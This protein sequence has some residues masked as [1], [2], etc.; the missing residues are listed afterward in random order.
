MFNFFLEKIVSY[1]NKISW[2]LNQFYLFL[3]IRSNYIENIWFKKKKTDFEK[4]SAFPSMH[5]TL[6]SSS[7]FTFRSPLIHSIF[8]PFLTPKDIDKIKEILF[9]FLINLSKKKEC[10][11]ILSIT[12][13]LLISFR[14]INGKTSK[15]IIIRKKKKPGRILRL[16]IHDKNWN[17]KVKKW[18]EIA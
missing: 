4:L 10:N 3:P 5:L 9:C 18:F 13:F 17:E 14:F 1:I 16:N 12:T 11:L 15:Y 2:I 7:F 6:Y 8:F